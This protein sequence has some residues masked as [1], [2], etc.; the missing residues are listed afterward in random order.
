MEGRG[1]KSGAALS[2]VGK[3]SAVERA[4]PPAE[5]NNAQADEW[6]SIVNRMP[7]EWFP[8][9][10]H[11]ILAQYCKHVISSQTISEMIETLLSLK[12]VPPLELMDPYDKLLK[13]Q[14]RE[15]RAMSSLATRM[16]IT[17]Q[18]T[19]SKDKQ[20]GGNAHKKPWEE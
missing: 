18:A 10:T 15:G 14:E 5:L 13:M 1:K 9:E 12:N 8:R 6:I 3:L 17:Q 7:A 4:E 11:A 2:V 20:K 16:R 19:Y